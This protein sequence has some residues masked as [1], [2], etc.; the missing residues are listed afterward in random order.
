MKTNLRMTE[1]W[2]RA[3][4]EYHA[5]LEDSPAADYLESRGLLDA[6]PDF[7]L[8]YVKKPAPGHEDRFKGMLAIPYQTPRGGVIGFKFRRLTSD[9]PKYDSPAGQR[10]HLFNVNAFRRA[11]ADIFVVEGELDAIAASHLGK[12]PAVAA[13]G[14]S[15]WKPHF[16]RCFDGYTRVIIITDN[17][18][19]DDEGRNPGDEFGKFLLETLPNAIRV[20]LPAGEDVNSTITNYGI[21]YFSALVDERLEV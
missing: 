10:H 15:S 4:D 7:K 21:E 6:A 20:S 12:L 11:I 5:S 2:T 18:A 1:M 19:K 9:L 14:V 8:G 3:A 17:D 16:T 13:P